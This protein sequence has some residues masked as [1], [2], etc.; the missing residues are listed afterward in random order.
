MCGKIIA[1]PEK[2]CIIEAAY[3]IKGNPRVYSYAEIG[4][5]CQREL[6]ILPPNIFEKIPF[7]KKYFSKGKDWS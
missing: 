4:E 1:N 6:G 2:R 3:Q 5:A 7:I